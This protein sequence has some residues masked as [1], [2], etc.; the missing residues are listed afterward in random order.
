MPS[1]LDP[2]REDADGLSV[3]IVGMAGR[4]PGADTVD[5]LW[6][7]LEMGK[8]AITVFDSC[9]ASAENDLIKFVPAGFVLSDIEKFD[10]SFFAMTPREAEITD[11]QHR[12]L[13]EC[14]FEALENA[15]YAG[16][17]SGI[18]VG[19]YVG[20]GPNGYLLNNIY[21]NR[22]VVETVSP[23]QLLIGNEKDY[24]AS[25]IAYKLDLKGPSVVV[26]S[27]CSTS[28]L[29]VHV[30][31][32]ALLG[33]ECDLA[34]AG[35]VS[36]ECP[37]GSGYR[38]EPGGI[39]SPDGRCR[40]FSAQAGGTVRGNG[41]AVVVLKRLD[42][43]VA[44]RDTIYAVLRGSATNNDGAAK[45]GYAAPSVEGQCRV[46]RAAHA[47][48]GVGA[49]TIGYVEAHGTATALGDPIEVAALSDAFR[50]S[51]PRPGPCMIGSLKSNIGHL[52][53]AAGAAGLI[54]AVLAL[55][56]E[57]IPASLHYETPN[58]RIDFS[59][60]TFAV[61]SAGMSWPRGKD[62]RRAGVSSFG[63]GGANVHVVLEEAPSQNRA[64]LRRGSVAILRL[65][66]MSATALA[67]AASRLADHLEQAPDLR[68]DDVAFSL[69]FGR[70]ALPHR[71]AV[72]VENLESAVRLLR[73]NVPSEVS[74]G[75]AGQRPP[76]VVLMFPGQGNQFIGMAAGLLQDG[77][78]FS[79]ELARCA[80]IM[81]PLLE[82]DLRDAI[83]PS[84]ECDRKGC[85][86]RLGETWLT[87]PVLFALEYAL[88]RQWM[89]WGL[90]PFAMIGH[91]LGEYVAACLAGVFSL[92]DALQL[93]CARGRLMHDLPEGS[94]MAVAVG[95]N[96]LA[97]RL[98]G[99][100]GLAAVNRFDL[101]VVSG[102]PS[103]VAALRA[104][105]EADEIVCHALPISRAFHSPMMD[106]CLPSL[107][108]LFSRIRL[109]APTIPFISNVTGSYI[110]AA[111]A[112]SPDYWTAQ[113]RSTVRFALGLRALPADE[114]LV[115]LECGPGRSLS[116]AARA[117][118]GGRSN[119]FAVAALPLE[120]TSV[121]DR[122]H[123]ARACAELW[124]RGLALA[125]DEDF[126]DAW[127]IPLPTYPFER[128]RH[129]IEPG[130][131]IQVVAGP[132]QEPDGRNESA[133]APTV[134]QQ[135][136][137][138]DE[139]LHERLA[140]LWSEALGV[141]EIGP[142]DDFFALG[143]DSITAMQ[144]AHRARVIG[145]SLRPVM[146]L[147]HPTI[148]R[149]AEV[150]E[151]EMSQSVDSA[152]PAAAFIAKPEEAHE[153]FPLTD[154]QHAYF[155]GRGA[156]VGS[157]NV[158]AHSYEE[159]DCDE[160]DIARLEGALN[161]L[162]RRH[163]MLRA[164]ITSDGRQRVLPAVPD[165]RLSPID[166]RPLEA[167]Q[168]E[169]RLAEIRRNKSHQVLP[170]ERWPLFDISVTLMP[171]GRARLHVS[172]DL[173]IADAWSIM[174][175]WKE[176]EQRY[177]DRDH[178]PLP[179]EVTYRDYVLA[180]D[181]SHASASFNRAKAY[182]LERAQSFPDAP[183]LPLACN[184]NSI[185]A[186]TFV[187]RTARVNVQ[188]WAKI[189]AVGAH[190]G[191]T[192]STLLCAVYAEVIAAWS[193]TPRFCLNLPA[194]NR[195]PIHPAIYDVIGDFTSILLLEVD[196]TTDQTFL[197]RAQGL[198]RQLW[199]DIAAL[200]FGGLKFLR[201]IGAYRL[202]MPI[203]PY[204]FTSLIFPGVSDQPAGGKIG[205]FVSGISQTPQVWL[206]CQVYEENG[207]LVFNWDSID[208]LFD[209]VMLDRMFDEFRHLLTLLAE[210][211]HIWTHNDWRDARAARF[212]GEAR[213]LA[214]LTAAEIPE[215]LLHATFLE[216]SG[217]DPA[218][219]ALLGSR[220]LTYGELA[221]IS[222]VVAGDLQESGAG[223]GARIAVVIDKGWE[224]VAAT[225]G[226]VRAGCAYVPVDPQ[227]PIARLNDIAAI[228]SIAAIV[229]VPELDASRDWPEGIPRIV[230]SDRTFERTTEWVDRG[231]DPDCL[232][233][234]TFTSGTTGQP[235]GV[236]ITHRAALN[237]IC[238]I[239][240][241]FAVGSADRVLALSALTFDLSVYDIFGLLE[242]GGAIVI[243]DEHAAR[244]PAHWLALATD[245]GV[246]IWNSVPALMQLLASQ[247][248]QSAKASLGNLRLVML[249][250]DWIPLDLASRV[251]A[252]APKAQVVSLGGATEASIWSIFHVI[253][254][255]DPSWRSIPY[256]RPLANQTLHVL[257][258]HLRP[259]PD[260]VAGELYICGV[261]LAQGY[262][263]NETETAAR[264][265]THP[266]TDTRL[267]RTGDLGRWLPDGRIE[268]LGRIDSQVKINGYRIE[269][270]E[271]EKACC[272][273]PA[274]RACVVVASGQ[275]RRARSLV[276]YAC[277]KPGARI[278]IDRLK[279]HLAER[280]PA[281]MVPATLVE[282]PTLPLSANGKVD[283]ARLP[284]SLALEAAHTRV[285]PETP[286][287]ARLID[288]LQAILGVAEVGATDDF[289]ECGG[290]SRQAIELVTRIRSE[291]T[292]EFPLRGA[293]EYPVIRDLARI[294]DAHVARRPAS[295]VRG[296]VPGAR[297]PA[298]P[299]TSAQMRVWFHHLLV[300]GNST[301]NIV[302]PFRLSG[303]LDADVLL[304]ALS[305]FVERHDALRMAFRDAPDGPL[306]VV[307]VHACP[308]LKLVDV[309]R[310]GR[311][312]A[313][314]RVAQEIRI[315]ADRPFD[316]V[317]GPLFRCRLVRL[318]AEDH[319]LIVAVH[320]I[321]WDGWST[322][323]MIRELGSLYRSLISGSEP[324][325]AV[326][327]LRFSDIAVW[328]Q[329]QLQSD[330]YREQLAYW[331]QQLHAPPLLA[332]PTD[333][334]SASSERPE[335]SREPVVIQAM[336]ASRFKDTCRRNGATLFMGYL[337]AW[338]TLLH[339]WCRQDD[340]IVGVPS[341]H[342]E[343]PQ[344]AEVIGF[345]VNS[346]AMRTRFAAGIDFAGLLGA[347]RETAVAAYS[348]QGV[349]FDRVVE[350][351]R[352]KRGM[353]ESAPVFRAWF[354]L[355]DVPMPAWELP[356]ISVSAIDA[357]F[358]LAVHDI[359]LSIIEKNGAME[360]GIDYR[361]TLFEAS[362]INRLRRCLV[363]LIETVAASPNIPISKLARTLEE[364]W[365]LADAGA[366]VKSRRR[367]GS[368]KAQ[369]I[370]IRTEANGV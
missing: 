151:A 351:L 5:V 23:I 231:G 283:R 271:I 108:T 13:L 129:W 40:P 342:R 87:Q 232:A 200:E 233:Y 357:E 330:T 47:V 146:I 246:T 218:A 285:S 264:F 345:L 41:A 135:A 239:N 104:A 144:V 136:R 171:G 81:R 187:R 170:A 59:G 80:E 319:V 22:R 69:R 34:L 158:A 116:G 64:P 265:L 237:T 354:V 281:Y 304:Q 350:Q 53:A 196:A 220:T 75:I 161:R 2:V 36:I 229:T 186:P 106:A 335:G 48:A 6:R 111:E 275:E 277:A 181:R 30:A 167:G 112:V 366:D 314:R 334:A 191:L 240:R 78:V 359:K 105:L 360:G 145:L 21:A 339:W 288:F 177:L 337:A 219:L 147:E 209:P 208:A 73:N 223:V 28:L 71:M 27:A 228:A 308:E 346:L 101:C 358:L 180:E 272:T 230:I 199:Q 152:A 242:A 297:G 39:L 122:L 90:R 270:G 258:A 316:L 178:D 154:I 260:G 217:S 79:A 198:Q 183:S 85:A 252:F 182:W 197:A 363:A 347:V 274:V 235:K 126:A 309:S 63:I 19:V 10:A 370:T 37:Q 56:R 169:A 322:A 74:R 203:M 259:R 284:S 110:T 226:A 293:F 353:S 149:L 61:A 162:I 298:A 51:H 14:A 49:D 115:L 58:P 321:V 362:T 102:P 100:L 121:S 326:S 82:M 91:S 139:T 267:Y 261:G 255:V 7:N 96:E 142:T 54:K 257:D 60:G 92:E 4:F 43:A 72:P 33:G 29:A 238:D 320:H 195:P 263:N 327:T 184:P 355:H 343:H 99:S 292:A 138:Q 287:E 329:E 86:S 206:D 331:A 312:A 189:K 157:G 280:L 212:V 176:L 289:F 20:C 268:F 133:A 207:D 266:R 307:G 323:I 256:G 318:A 1:V 84:K 137:G 67:Q 341:G 286:T 15:G 131:G 302:E 248:E 315:Q 338:Q 241:R 134:A 224:Q 95:E 332:L 174:L 213:H 325:P 364:T 227:W 245:A 194:F 276:L 164:V 65:S 294:V 68:L 141:E 324:A 9:R 368:V 62:R 11:P 295:E 333:R 31:A 148:E 155:V 356:G 98:G 168:A 130:D 290:D 251:L 17:V 113:L 46:I 234:I 24:L 89:A 244:D 273:H 254:Q 120:G 306:Q 193:E 328:E 369:R 38:Y 160:L 150:L 188:P 317:N 166:L 94:M 201:A 118:P 153:A 269:T 128:R 336:I 8:E 140:Q 70:K 88:A 103:D 143:G 42:D 262:F 25:R 282:L 301:Y 202:T 18:E 190:H 114:D 185:K 211:E 253:E 125:G 50:S 35:G 26:Q 250:G 44:D 173:L 243:P 165:Y 313:E 344:T 310:A 55:H 107:A 119:V 279:S 340:I 300:P 124:C 163:P 225:I 192:P 236:M 221:R 311:S 305:H 210:Y 303:P 52:D 132:A 12:V 93:V 32:R 365:A 57:H 214:N 109:N 249:S 349:P 278:E 97:S 66:A 352:P 3:A 83:Y 291:F 175:F 45:V 204:V 117:I 77:P 367:W 76:K 299:L 127:R 156:G 159:F 222:A 205:R 296:P 172:F 216:R 247:V 179:V 16:D 348:N 215:R 361:T 123:T